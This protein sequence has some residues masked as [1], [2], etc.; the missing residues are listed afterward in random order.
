MA[1]LTRNWQ[2]NSKEHF[3]LVDEL[4]KEVMPVKD[5]C[6]VPEACFERLQVESEEYITEKEIIDP[7]K[8]KQ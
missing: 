4:L 2:R 3:S 7:K 8:A 1:N 5:V 6:T